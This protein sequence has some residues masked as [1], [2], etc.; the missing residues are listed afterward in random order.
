[1]EIK[2]LQ[3]RLEKLE[4]Q[5]RTVDKPK[6]KTSAEPSASPEATIP[7]P[8]KTDD[9]GILNFFNTGV[10]LITDKPVDGVESISTDE[11][12]KLCWG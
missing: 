8:G 12:L 3:E 4:T 1:M 11:G 7:S 9:Q 5:Q 2:Q 6:E 10:K